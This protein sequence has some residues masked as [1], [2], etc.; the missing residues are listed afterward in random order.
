[1]L[2]VVVGAIGHV[3]SAL[4]RAWFKLVRNNKP[5][6]IVSVCAI[7]LVVVLSVDGIAHAGRAYP[8]V[9]VGDIDVS[10]LTAAEI[11]QAVDQTYS[12]PLQQASATVF[13]SDEA[14][15]QTDEAAAA[16]N[17]QDA[18]LAEQMAVDEAMASKKAWQTTGA[19]LGAT[20][21]SAQLAEQA[22]AVG[23]GDGGLFARMGAGLFGKRIEVEPSF[24]EAALEEFASGIDAAI[25]QARVDYDVKVSG[26]VAYVVQGNDGWEVNRQTLAQLLSGTMLGSSDE[27]IIA[28]TEFTPVRISSDAA[29]EVAQDVT[30]AL[31]GGARFKFEGH[32]WQ[33]T[34]S[35]EEYKSLA[36]IFIRAYRFMRNTFTVKF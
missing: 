13:A 30:S 19:D 7:A 15:Q 29:A 20:L 26:G 17:Q 32:T 6:R 16:Q 4:L 8:G 33:A 34:A 27:R 36:C 25:G 5:A 9:K 23:R 2:S 12:Q 14:A 22:L 11:E 21:D 10:G 35:A 24:D 28:H 31:S 18:A 3:L 1:M